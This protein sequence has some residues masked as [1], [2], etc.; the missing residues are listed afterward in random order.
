MQLI[1]NVLQYENWTVPTGD[2]FEVPAETRAA[3]EKKGH[4]L[5]SL[6]GGTICQFVLQELNSPNAGQLIGISDP[7]KGGFPAGF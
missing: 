5:Q 2:H 4:I 6:A 1:P 7:R 3:L